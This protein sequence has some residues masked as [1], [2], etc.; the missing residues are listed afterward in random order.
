M[1]LLDNHHV[2]HVLNVMALGLIVSLSGMRQHLPLEGCHHTITDKVLIVLIATIQQTI[3][4]LH[5]R[6]VEGLST[7]KNL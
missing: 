3:I 1:L 2:G 6:D 5:V 4:I 7:T